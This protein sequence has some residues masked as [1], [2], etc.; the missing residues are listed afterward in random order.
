MLTLLYNKPTAFHYF[1]L[2]ITA[3]VIRGATFY[4]YVQHAERYQ[5]A[6]SADYHV[7]ALCMAHGFGMQRPDKKYIFLIS[8][9]KYIY[10]F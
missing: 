9:L 6:D 8:L 5:Q 2:F 4:F 10:F 1:L 7:A 3:F